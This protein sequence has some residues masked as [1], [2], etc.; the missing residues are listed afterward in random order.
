MI[1]AKGWSR[2]L[3]I[4]TVI[5]CNLLLM[6]KTQAQKPKAI[7]AKI[8]QIVVDAKGKNDTEILVLADQAAKAYAA[9]VKAKAAAKLA[10]VQ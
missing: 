5:T 9:Q 8:R 10:E 6:V 2:A 7:T 1:D 4:L 3:T